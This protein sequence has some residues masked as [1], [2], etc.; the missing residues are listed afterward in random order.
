MLCIRQR[1]L[2]T[3][4]SGAQV[5]T[6]ACLHWPCRIVTDR[7]TGRP[8]G[9]GFCEYYDIATAESAFRNLNGY[10][11]NGR[12]IRIDFAED[13]QMRGKGE[14]ARRARCLVKWQ[15]L[16][17][18]TATAIIDSGHFQTPMQCVAPVVAAFRGCVPCCCLLRNCIRC[19]HVQLPCS[20][21]R[22]LPAC[23]HLRP[24]SGPLQATAASN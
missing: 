11:F 16:E 4:P 9:F 2:C 7:E 17:H 24:V 3:R 23:M 8:K 14:L 20:F 12:T 10:E 22:P 15:P 19:C 6:H 5:G 21:L 13:F 18:N 1:L